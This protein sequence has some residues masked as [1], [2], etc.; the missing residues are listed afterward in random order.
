MRRERMRVSEARAGPCRHAKRHARGVRHR[1]AILEDASPVLGSGLG[2]TGQ[3]GDPGEVPGEARG[4]RWPGAWGADFARGHGA[5][6]A[7][8]RSRAAERPCQPCCQVAQL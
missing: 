3:A 6:G 2:K 1:H 5:L 8:Q 7:G 4:A